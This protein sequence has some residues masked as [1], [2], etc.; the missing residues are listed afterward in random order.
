MNCIIQKIFDN[1]PLTDD[2]NRVY[3]EACSIYY[4]KPQE[5][6]YKQWEA[7]EKSHPGEYRKYICPQRTDK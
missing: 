3:D 5:E 2:E 6:S 4:E 7:W 1:E